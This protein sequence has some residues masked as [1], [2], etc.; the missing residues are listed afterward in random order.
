MKALLLLLIFLGSLNGFAQNPLP[1]VL[2]PSSNSVVLPNTENISNINKSTVGNSMAEATLAQINVPV[3]TSQED[4]D[5]YC[6]K[7][8]FSI[9]IVS[10]TDDARDK[11]PQQEFAQ[12]ITTQLFNTEGELKNFCDEHEIILSIGKASMV[13]PAVPIPSDNS[14]IGP[15]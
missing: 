2:S 13:T 10:V 6:I 12:T 14:P 1:T 5:L 4:F 7:N 3:F 9:T 8:N 11:N 15:K